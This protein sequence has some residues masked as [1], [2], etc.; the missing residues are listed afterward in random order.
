MADLED[1][2][3]LRLT[4]VTK[5]FGGVHALKGVSLSVRAGEV[6]A[7]LGENGAGKST[8]MAIAAGALE[9][10]SG[11]VEI[12]GEP[13]GSAS[14]SAAQALGLG[15]VYQH[16]AIADD[17]SVL[18]NMLLAMP[19][20]RRPSQ[21]RA[22]AWAQEQ[23]DAVGAR[24]DP[25]RRATELS[26]AEHQLVEIA[27]ALAL[28]PRVLILDEPTA[29]LGAAEVA[30]L[31]EQV[32]A[33]RARGTAVVYISHR[34]PEV[35]EIADRLTV[36]RDG[37]NRGTFPVAELT[38]DDILKLI[39]G[40]Q[41]DAVF[42]DKPIGGPGAPVLRV[43]GLSGEAF[44]DVSLTIGAGEI[45]GLAGVVGNG[46]QE[47]IR[48]LAGLEP[49]TGQIE[50]HGKAISVSN[51]VQA[52]RAG[53]AYVPA[54]RQREGLFPS[55]S[56]RE[57]AA[58]NALGSFATSGFVRPAAERG[59]VATESRA[60]AVKAASPE[61]GV[62][63][64]S[65]GNQQKVVFAR[66]LLGEPEVL[67]CDE[68]TQ[69][70]DVGA[71]VEIYAL[72]RK[73]ADE[74]KAVVVCSSDA[75]ELE[76]LCD[77]VVI[78]S[79][80]S[81]VAELTGDEIS[82]ER[83]TGSAV[84]AAGARRDR[85]GGGG[86]QAGDRRSRPLARLLRSDN[87]AT[88]IVALLVVLLAI[89]TSAQDSAFLGSFNV[90][91]LLLLSTALILVSMGQ[92]F[93][94]LTGG[95]DLSVGPMMG[96]GV[97]ILTHHATDSGGTSGFL[98]GLLLL[99]LAGIGVGLVNGA[100]VRLAKIPPVI[101]TLATYAAVGG[102]A[103]VINPVPTGLLGNSVSKSL[104][105]SVGGTLPWVFLGIVILAV[106]LEFAL[107]RSRPG[108]AL[109]AVGS[110]EPTAHRVGVKVGLTVFAAYV[111][112]SVLAALAAVM[113]ALQIGTGDA[114]SGQS[115]T[116]QSVAAVVVGG[117]S[118]FGGRGTFLGTLLGALLLTEVINALPFLQLGN[119]WQFWVPG[120]VV[121]VAAG[122]YARATK[123][124]RSAAVD[125][126]T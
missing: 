94:L 34:I 82:E 2:I 86:E 49:Q 66:A 92:L 62:M 73:L 83:I 33:I 9:Q 54:D 68:P 125:A 107:R 41:I 27:K 29:A 98:V 7:L 10:D 65:G 40:R 99:L 81:A 60:L 26:A 69:G 96:L 38:P 3:E 18:E 44:D 88:P 56:V 64:L 42:P 118:I 75:L 12:G 30:H 93:V 14:P 31:F 63:T 55:L 104:R 37:S 24:I 115:Y 123:A 1:R 43:S 67:L 74:G 13:L 112:C 87:V 25:D 117:A 71:R 52:R 84:N 35:T 46:Q 76:G 114:T 23:L 50:V 36:L 113:L 11:A 5:A 124:N 8:L 53:I 45:V 32:R 111:A 106:A 110:S 108:M 101:A 121:L 19:G 116:L 6:H 16:P 72:I 78:M 126:A 89:Y 39:V 47:L 90:N 17:L 95:V 70:V 21:G 109:R 58:A 120:A 22:R 15:V 4:D 97:V 122:I 80:G 28:E 48:A 79:R 85:A 57:N 77:R 59:A 103:L 102:L 20:E 51:P 91:N 119:A 100:L 105:S 61:I